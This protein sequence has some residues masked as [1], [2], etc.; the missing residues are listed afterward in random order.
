MKAGTP[1]SFA[2][3]V[4]VRGMMISATS[5]ITAPCSLLRYTGCQVSSFLAEQPLSTP[6]TAGAEIAPPIGQATRCNNSRRFISAFMG[7]LMVAAS[8]VHA[9]ELFDRMVDSSRRQRHIG[10]RG[11]LARGRRH[12][13]AVGEDRKSTR[14]NSSH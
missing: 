4:S 14:L 7:A 3:G 11:V 13:R 8:D 12:A 5:A 1:A 6:S 10:Q 2:P 9:L